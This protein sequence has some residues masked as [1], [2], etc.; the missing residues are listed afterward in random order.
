MAAAAR[1]GIIGDFNAGNPTHVATDCSLQHAAD[2]L[3]IAIEAVWL[4]T[5]EAHDYGKFQ[6]LFCSP[7]SPYKSLDRAL[8]G[9]RYAREHRVPFIGTCGGFQHLTIEYARNVMGLRD[10]AHAESDPYASCL[11]ATPLSCSLVG[12]TM[13][14]AVKPGS[15][16]ARA[17]GATQSMEKFYCNFGLNPEYQEELEKHGLEITGRDQNNEARIVEF[18]PHPFFL[19]TLFVPQASSEAWNPHRLM[20][21]FCRTAAAHAI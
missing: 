19:G 12:K 9:I 1:I 5:D 4:P 20:L 21:E 16:A 10:A 15:K 3:G 2:A 18:P 13:E 6:G 17:F 14:V 7:G 11:F 8:I